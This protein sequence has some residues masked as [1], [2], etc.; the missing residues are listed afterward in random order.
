MRTRKDARVGQRQRWY[1][2]R[3]V[4]REYYAEAE[5]VRVIRVDTLGEAMAELH[6]FFQ[7]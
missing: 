3:L 1:Y 7:T 6:K 2:V 4:E 5:T